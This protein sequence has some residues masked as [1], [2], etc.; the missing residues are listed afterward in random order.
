MSFMANKFGFSLSSCLSNSLSGSLIF[1][2]AALAPVFAVEQNLDR[3][4]SSVRKF[5]SDDRGHM[6]AAGGTLF[7]GSSTFQHWHSLERQFA[8]IKAI[9][10]GFGGST[11]P[12]VNHYFDRLVAAYKP[13]RIVFYAGTND[14]ADGHSAARVAAD[15]KTFLEKAHSELPGDDV[16]FISMS[17]PPCRMQFFKEYIEGN[18]L[19]KAMV[20]TDRKLKYIDV[21]AVMRD[22]DGKLRADYFGPDNLHMNDKG[23]SAWEPIIHQALTK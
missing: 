17:V 4:E 20:E 14:I 9:N 13:A 7:I 12:E 2:L 5:E 22:K 18:R 15:F 3:F 16:Y 1:I 11:I 19:I 21:T 10:H 23:Y 6:P 8:D